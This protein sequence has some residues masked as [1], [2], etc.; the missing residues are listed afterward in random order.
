MPAPVLE[1][2][3]LRGAGLHT[4]LPGILWLEPRESGAGMRFFWPGSGPL[5]A[6]D[7]GALPRL[8]SRCTLLRAGDADIRM[9]EHLLAAA[10][11][12]ADCPVDVRCEAA[13]PPGLDGSALPFRRAFSELFP[14]AADRPSWTEYPSRL[15]FDYEGPEGRLQA[16]PAPAFSVDYE[17]DRGPL[18]QRFLLADAETAMRD[19]LPA[20]TFIFL[21]EWEA[22]SRQPG[23]LRGAG[24][25]SG[26]LYADTPEEF[27]TAC[28]ARPELRG[29]CFPL[30]HPESERLEQEAVKHKILDLLGDLALLDLSLPKL[31]LRIRNGGHSLNHLLLERLQH[32]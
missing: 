14:G 20:R 4:G 23:L 27:A 24:P 10:L 16:E 7:L 28:M 1:R 29:K 18:S 31:R 15:R 9:P 12:F 21:R 8:A 26:L 11:F 30:L 19:I 5:K 25:G 2:V 17:L 22:A 13:E 3:A 32:E 6:S